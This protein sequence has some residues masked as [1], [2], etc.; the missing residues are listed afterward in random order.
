MRY[1]TDI[2]LD[3]AIVHILDPGQSNGYIRSERALPLAAN[4]PLVDYFT[5]HV[6]NSLQDASASAARFVAIS[7]GSTAEICSGLLTGQLDLVD[8]SRSLADRLYHIIAR[9]K[10]IKGGSLVVC[11]YHSADYP[12]VPAFWHCSR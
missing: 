9:D 2:Q 5:G 8:G 4:P 12:K 6:R 3:Q 11:L 10:R 1:I 7:P